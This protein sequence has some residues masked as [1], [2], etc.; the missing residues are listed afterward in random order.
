M[1][2]VPWR[3]SGRA[4]VDADHVQTAL[5]L[6]LPGPAPLATVAGTR[7]GGAPDRGVA[8]VVQWV[9]GQVV[10]VDVAPEI[11]LGPVGQ[12]VDLPDLPR[13]VTVELWRGGPRG[14][15]L[16]ANPRDPG[17]DAVERALERLH[18]RV[19]AAALER[20]RLVGAARVED[21]DGHPEALLEALPGL[22]RL[23]E[24]DAGV[25]R[26]HARV[27]A[28]LG[29]H[30]HEH[31]LL[32]LEGAGRDQPGVEAV[33]GVGDDLLRGGAFQVGGQDAHQTAHSPS[34]RMTSKGAFF[35]QSMK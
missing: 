26:E 23:G 2:V 35:V 5:G 9:V 31:R 33:D 10:R 29:E 30:V 16:A 17:L 12:R 7:A 21:L 15:L 34:P 27:R 18:L 14:R 6:L 20:P 28:G 11:L 3:G 25:D 1:R 13:A 4:T 24:E 8:A 32:L 22:E 19:A